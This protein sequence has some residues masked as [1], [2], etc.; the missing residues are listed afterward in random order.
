MSKLLSKAHIGGLDLINRVIMPPM[1][2]YEVKNKDGIPTPFHFAH[3]GSKAISKVSLIIQEATAVNKDGR[4]TDYDLGIWNDNQKDELKKL[5]DSI[6]YLGSKIGIQLVHAG[7]KAQD[8]KEPL[9]PS[10]IEY[11]EPFNK[12]IK[13][14]VDQIKETIKNFI[15]AAKRADEAGYDMIELHGAHGYLISQFLSPLS[16]QREDEYGGSLENRYRFLKEIIEG[17][18]LVSDKPIWVRLSVDAY[19]EAGVQ[20]SIEDWKQV[21]I[22]LQEQGVKC[23]DVSTGGVLNKKP[24]NIF[25]G[26]Q[27]SYATKLKEV[28]S[29]DVVTVGLIDDPR[30]AEYILQNNQADG[31]LVG[32]GLLRN[33]N[34]LNDAA[35]ILHDKEF[36]VFNNSYLRSQK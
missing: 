10:G 1:C 19:D 7:R 9:S 4:L 8:V 25:P 20:N 35:K 26:F 2:M 21:A 18:K 16:N 34:W 27:T 33:S 36:T 17:V 6:H 29:I 32:R 23:I 24:E 14:T 11:G 13:M 15:N 3:Y 28:V 12:P 22:W 31:I 30:L 5:V